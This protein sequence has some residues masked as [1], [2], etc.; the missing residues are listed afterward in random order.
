MHFRTRRVTIL[1]DISTKISRNF[2]IDVTYFRHFNS[3]VIFHI[4]SNNG[5]I[6]SYL[7]HNIK[8]FTFSNFQSESINLNLV[9]AKAWNV[10]IKPAFCFQLM[11][12]LFIHFTVQKLLKA[13]NVI[14]NWLKIKMKTSYQ[15]WNSS[16]FL[17][18]QQKKLNKL[19]VYFAK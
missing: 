10:I 9:T 4:S 8:H 3:Q 11:F 12:F 5:F 13:C 14:Y 18:V 1:M 6:L 15:L 17:V 2:K 19:D 7:R 16:Y